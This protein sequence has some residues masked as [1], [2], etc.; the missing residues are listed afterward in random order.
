MKFLTNTKAPDLDL[1]LTHYVIII[2][3]FLKILMILLMIINE[4]SQ[5]IMM[6]ITKK[7]G[8]KKERCIYIYIY[9]CVVT[10]TALRT[11]RRMD[12]YI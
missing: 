1:V 11:E 7:R 2:I 4:I 12:A 9:I 10:R 6:K 3:F 8:D 5:I